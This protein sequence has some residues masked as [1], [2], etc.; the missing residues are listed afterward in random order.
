MSFWVEYPFL[1]IP[2]Y[3]SIWKFIDFLFPPHCA[4]CGLVGERFCPDCSH[5][6]RLLE[7]QICE[8]C[9]EPLTFLQH[10]IQECNDHLKSLK[11]IRSFSFY[12]P[13]LSLAIQKLKYH[14]DIGIAEVLAIYLVELYNKNKMDIDMVI[15]VPL[16]KKRLHDRG[17]NQSFLLALPFSMMIN[18]PIKK[19]SLRRFKDTSSQVGLD[20]HERLINVSE[21]FI[22]DSD[23]VNGKN[24]LLIDDVSTTGSTLEACAKAL[25]NAGAKDIVGLTLARAVHTRNGFSDQ[26]NDVVTAQNF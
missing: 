24:I 26:L 12:Q 25:K 20:R 5:Q 6:V 19:Q 17:Y 10:N 11:M 16:S 18:K 1:S 8:K 2:L 22:A 13:P 3:R 9:G 21:A 4:G 14:R 15:P 7:G 23:E